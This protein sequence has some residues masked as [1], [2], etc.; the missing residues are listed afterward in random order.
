MAN[1]TLTTN[2]LSRLS[3]ANHDGGD[4][5]DDSGGGGLDE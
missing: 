4:G 2:Y 5:G 3:N 1:K